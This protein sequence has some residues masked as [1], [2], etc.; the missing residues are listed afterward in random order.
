MVFIPLLI[1]MMLLALAARMDRKSSFEDGSF[2]IQIVLLIGGAGLVFG[3]LVW[4]F[5]KLVLS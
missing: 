1:G 5:I 2:L 3:T 4:E